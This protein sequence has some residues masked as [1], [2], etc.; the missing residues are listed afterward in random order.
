MFNSLFLL[1]DG[2]ST[3]TYFSFPSR[4]CNRWRYVTRCHIV[5]MNN[6]VVTNFTV[7]VDLALW[8]PLYFLI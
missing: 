1:N 5:V 8:L 2:S 6:T 7:K 3:V 4:A